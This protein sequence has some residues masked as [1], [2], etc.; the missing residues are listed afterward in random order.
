MKK[1]SLYIALISVAFTSYAQ[2]VEVDLS[3]YAEDVAE[4]YTAGSVSGNQ[5]IVNYLGGSSTSASVALQ[6]GDSIVYKL[7]TGDYD[8]T[9]S[10][11]IDTDTDTL[12][13]E[14]RLRINTTNIGD[15]ITISQSFAPDK[16]ILTRELDSIP[17]KWLSCLP[18]YNSSLAILASS[19]RS[20]F[21]KVT[22]A[23]IGCL[24]ILS[25]K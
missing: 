17:R 9:N 20:P 1:V 11:G 12:K 19:E 14:L 23:A 7:T 22:C 15:A 10:I 2:E 24:W 5:K 4:G 18:P 8:A 3:S 25:I 16:G 13:V 21:S 6:D